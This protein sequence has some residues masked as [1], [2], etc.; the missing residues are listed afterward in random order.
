MKTAMKHWSAG[1]AFACR[2]DALLSFG[3]RFYTRTIDLSGGFPRTVSL[4]SGGMEWAAE[5]KKGCDCSFSGINMP[6]RCRLRGL[7]RI[8]IFPGK[9]CRVQT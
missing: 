8:G 2:E 5:D 3:N 1:N 4:K 9:A 6:G 7:S